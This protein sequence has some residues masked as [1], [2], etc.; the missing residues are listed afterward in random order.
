MQQGAIKN[1]LVLSAVGIA[2]SWGLFFF[3]SALSALAVLTGVLVFSFFV[4]AKTM[5]ED[6]QIYP[7]SKLPEQN[8]Q[9][10]S[11]DIEKASE[12]LSLSLRRVDLS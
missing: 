2:V 10:E 9:P 4:F 8:G 12:E 3:A 5:S 7:D 1:V 6:E 11:A